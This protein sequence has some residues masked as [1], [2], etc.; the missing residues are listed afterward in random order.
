MQASDV[1]YLD[2]AQGFLVI[3]TS[4]TGSA[5][6]ALTN[7]SLDFSVESEEVL[8]FEQ[9][10]SKSFA[11]TFDSWTVSCEGFFTTLTGDTSHP[12]SGS[13]YVTGGQNGADLLELI[14]TKSNSQKII[15]KLQD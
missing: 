14:K 3:T 11:T 1:K 10:R 7:I 13:T 15:L 4:T 9:N 8:T 5:I 6:L 2:G 12:A